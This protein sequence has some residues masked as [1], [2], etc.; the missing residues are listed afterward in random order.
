MRG[1]SAHLP[2]L[3]R[4]LGLVLGSLAILL[5]ASTAPASAAVGLGL[6]LVQDGYTD[7]V[8]V[9]NA[10]D[11]RL[12]VVEQTGQIE[13]VGGGTFLDISG[14]IACCGER[15]LLGLAFHPQRGGLRQ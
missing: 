8:F 10:G 9:T 3:L 2:T 11:D 6:S 15:G 1:T 13:I 5:T 12:F 7:P 14:K 4:R